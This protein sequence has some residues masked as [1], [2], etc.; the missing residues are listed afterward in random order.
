MGIDTVVPQVSRI[1]RHSP[2]PAEPM[3]STSGPVASE[4][5]SKRQRSAAIQPDDPP[6]REAPMSRTY[7]EDGWLHVTL[8]WWGWLLVGVIALALG[9]AATWPRL[10]TATRPDRLSR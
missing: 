4:N 7:C 6:D 8:V 1:S 3:L 2:R 9:V 10:P 5:S